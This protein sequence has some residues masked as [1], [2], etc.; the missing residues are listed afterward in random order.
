MLKVFLLNQINYCDTIWNKLFKKDIFNGKRFY[1]KM[2]N[3]LTLTY[4]IIMSS[5]NVI[6]SNQV[7][8]FYY[9]NQDCITIKKKHDFE[10]NVEIYKVLIQR[11]YDIKKIYPSLVENDICMA[12]CIIMLYSRNNKEL[13]EYLNDEGAMQLYK[14]IYSIGMLKYKLP[15]KLKLKFIIF[16]ISPKLY[17]S[18]ID[19]YLKLKGA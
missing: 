10:R 8:Y 1:N 11:Y 2:I 7:K 15:I 12:R 18:A 14:K 6:Y 19:T 17:Q 5:K 9:R 16:S 4:K 3:D 13:R